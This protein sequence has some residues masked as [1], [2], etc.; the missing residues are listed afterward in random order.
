MMI[1]TCRFCSKT[2]KTSLISFAKAFRDMRPKPAPEILVTGAMQPLSSVKA[3]L[4]G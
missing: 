2:G 3:L 1:E 4:A